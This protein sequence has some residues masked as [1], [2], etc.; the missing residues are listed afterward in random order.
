MTALAHSVA[1]VRDIERVQFGILSPDEIKA[2]SVAKIEFP[3]AMENGMQKRGGLSDPRMG[4]VERQFKCQTC[5][6]SMGDCP[7]HFGHIELVKP[8][9]NVTMMTKI[10][11]TLKSVCYHCSRLL[12]S[13]EDM[14]YKH[15]QR[16]NNMSERFR[17]LST[18]CF[19]K[20][21]CGGGT[22]V[23]ADMKPSIDLTAK[24]RTGCGNVQ[25]K[26]KRDGL[27][28]TYE[29]RLTGAKK[30][31]EST[32]GG[33]SGGGALPTGTQTLSPEKAHE[34]LKR[35]SDEDCRALGFNPEQGRP[36]W[37]IITV[38]P[39]PPMTV[40][41][42]VVM[43]SVA[44]GIDDLTHKLADIIKANHNLRQQELRGSPAH[45]MEE[46]TKLLQYH[47]ATYA[48]NEIPGVATAQQKSGRPLKSIRQRMKGKEGRIRG[49]LMGKRV[50]FSARTVITADPNLS[51]DEVGVPR[52]IALNLTFPEMVTPYNID[53]MYELVRRGALEHPGAKYVIRDDGTRIDLRFSRTQGQEIHLEPGY[54]VERHIVDG[55]PVIFNRQ[56]SLHKMSMMGHRIRVLPWSTF[57]LNLSVTT[58]YN[59]DFDGDEMN[60]HVPQNLETRAEVTEIMSVSR[61]ILTP[62]GNRP[63]MGIVQDTLTGSRKLTKRDTFIEMDL[64]MQLLMWLPGWTGHVPQPAILKPR[65]MWTGKQIFSMII[66]AEVNLTRTHSTHDDEEDKGNYVHMSPSDTKVLIEKG[67][68]LSGIICKKTLGPSAGGL[69]HILFKEWGHEVARNFFNAC[70]RVVN[71][72]LMW[73]GHS[74]GIG[75]AVADDAT[76]MQV[77]DAIRRAKEDVKKVV[78]SAQHGRLESTPGNTLR[79]TFENE[80]NKYLNNAREDAGKKVQD[81]LGD[82]N[83]FRLMAVAGSK[84][85]VLNISQVIACV[86]QQN[87]EGKRIPFG[88][89]FRTLPHFVKD[90]YGPESRGFVEN[91]YLK[92]LTPSEFFFHA[93]GGREGVIDTAVKTSETGYIQRRLVKCMEDV[94]VKYDGTVRNSL[95]D[96]IQFVYGEDGLDGAHLEFG[97]QPILAPNNDR[98]NSLY[99]YDDKTLNELSVRL[100]PE[101]YENVMTVEMQDALEREFNQL[102]TDRTLLRALFPTGSGMLDAAVPVNVP[103]LIWN[104]Q[105]TFNIDKRHQSDLHPVAVIEGVRRLTENL[106][107]VKGSDPISVEAQNNAICLFGIHLR[108]VLNS[109]R[110]LL[111]HRLHSQAFEWLLGEIES[112]FQQAKVEPGEMVGALAAQS[113]GEPA[114]Q[115]TLNTF[116]FA[117]VSAKNVT[118]GVPRLREL[119]NVS[120]SPKTPSLTVYLQ[121]GMDQERAKDVA[122]RLEHTTL[123]KIT[124]HTEI[125]YDPNPL[126]SV[127]E[128]DQSFVNDYYEMPD[129]PEILKHISPWLLRMELDRKQMEYRRLTMERVAEKITADF[130]NDLHVIFSDDNADKLILQI[131]MLKKTSEG[132]GESGDKNPEDELRSGAADDTFLRKLIPNYLW[133]LTLQGLEDIA[134]VYMTQKNRKHFHPVTGALVNDKNVKEWV[135]E[136][137]GSSLLLALSQPNVDVTRTVSNDIVEI[138]RVLGVEAVRQ[139]L[140]KEMHAVYSLYGIYINYRH[141]A[142]LCDVMTARGHIMAVTR[143]GINGLDTGPLMRCS[144]EETVEILVTAAQ[145]S[146]TDWLRGPSENII[147]GQLAPV[148]TGYF[149]LL[150]NEKMLEHAVEMPQTFG[151]NAFMDGMFDPLGISSPS[152]GLSPMA[153]TQYHTNEGYSVYSPNS[154]SNAAF[155]PAGNA[156][157]SPAY[158][159]LSPFN[160]SGRSPDPYAASSPRRGPASPYHAAS[161]SYSP[162]DTDYSPSSG[163]GYSPTSPRYSPTSPS[164]SPTSPSY[165]PTSP[166]YSPT[167]PSY[168]PTSPS[169]SPTSPSYSPTSPSYSPTSPSYSPTSPSYSPTSPSY[170]PT[171]PSYSPTSP[172]YSPTSP[173]YSPTSPSYSPTS[174]SYSPTSPSYSPTSPSYSPTSPSYSPTS[175]SYSPTS[176]SYSPNQPQPPA[177][178]RGGNQQQRR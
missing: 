33:G 134:K 114:T 25:P 99:K 132:D 28:L 130:G 37:M 166:S 110:V 84:G 178:Q 7:G 44:R 63:V 169:Y 13:P 6:G 123:L 120:K 51:L 36:D 23:D 62:A 155:S 140:F 4:T 20:T 11:K 165:S 16:T 75:D 32:A 122:C 93:M 126:A 102:A 160:Q 86:G 48:D 71:Y 177:N 117:G 128:E 108:S 80:V 167:S 52:S 73:E 131:R 92:G 34:I 106:V 82:F 152:A 46:Y 42:S 156:S 127:V 69:I 27:S 79:E 5:T 147:L 118:L 171:S 21:R 121:S 175:P 15:A 50:D 2:M 100:T 41:P 157:F 145:H 26:Y 172:S 40:R 150:L 66:P 35:I 57:R 87:V 112:R 107:I 76:M 39:V 53:R 61:Q 31:S 103:R 162:G 3:D 173:S 141:L 174:P 135:L 143:H 60:L 153:V 139:S 104:A 81:S 148:G 78:E 163:K 176:P 142:L 58:P 47:V 43:D 14:A 105:K 124:T 8:V 119:I 137:D 24:A 170:S 97:N 151:V 22:D 49:N 161:P 138:M 89:R 77:E 10:Q 109:K 67:R 83:N 98:F 116:H 72:W 96:V 133:P 74:I 91:S 9:F 164:Y 95:G 70:Q 136:T 12:V 38:L 90:D 17:R 94:M 168:S 30:D 68:L 54:R 88:F 125:Y 29:F 111:E 85:S 159:A 149:D 55:D 115:M 144:F 154:P 1:P 146:E 64:M 65:P 19:G 59:A 45:I 129:D 56:P 113:L 158:G 101:I 18:A